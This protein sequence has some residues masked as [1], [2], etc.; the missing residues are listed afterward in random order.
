MRFTERDLTEKNRDLLPH[1]ATAQANR[2]MYSKFCDT[3]GSS[4]REI[5]T[6]CRIGYIAELYM[7]QQPGW[8]KSSHIHYDVED[9][10][11]KLVEIKT[12]RGVH[13]MSH[14]YVR[15]CVSDYENGKQ[16]WSKADRILFFKYSQNENWDLVYDYVGTYLIRRN[17]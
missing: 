10:E 11:G 1:L 3:K 6:K 13:S 17:Q 9:H 8:K 7:S 4:H 2:L 5:Y 12:L 14:Q 16:N 15:W